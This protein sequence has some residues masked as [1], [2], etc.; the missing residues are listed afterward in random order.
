LGSGKSYRQ[1]KQQNGPVDKRGDPYQERAQ[2][3]DEHRLLCSFLIW[4]TS[5]ISRIYDQLFAPTRLSGER[6]LVRSF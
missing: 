1:G 2:Q 5:F 3:V 4:I 6:K